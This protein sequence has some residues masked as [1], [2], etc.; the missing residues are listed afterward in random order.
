MSTYKFGSTLIEIVKDE[1]D[2]LPDYYKRK[3]EDTI[4]EYNILKDETVKK[5]QY[6]DAAKLRFIYKVKIQTQ[7]TNYL[8]E[9]KL[10]NEELQNYINDEN[11]S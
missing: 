1:Y 6:E 3:L 7:A 8:W 11:N 9:W 2:I 10:Y 5:Q 4:I